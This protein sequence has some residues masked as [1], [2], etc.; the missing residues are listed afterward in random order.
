M[1]D[2]F[3]PSQ[4]SSEM[5]KKTISVVPTRVVDL[6]T[7]P[8]TTTIIMIPSVAAKKESSIKRRSLK[9][10]FCD[11]GSQT[12]VPPPH[13]KKLCELVNVFRSTL[14]DKTKWPENPLLLS[15]VDAEPSDFL[16]E[17][18]RRCDTPR[19]LDHLA[20]QGCGNLDH[21]Q[22]ARNNE[23]FIDTLELLDELDQKLD[24]LDQTLEQLDDKM[25]LTTQLEQQ[26]DEL[27]DKMDQQIDQLDDKIDQQFDQLEEKMDQQLDELED[28]MDLSTGSTPYLDLPVHPKMP[29]IVE[30]YNTIPVDPRLIRHSKLCADIMA[31]IRDDPNW[32]GMVDTAL[33]FRRTPAT[34]IDFDKNLFLKL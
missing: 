24:H 28:K 3:T 21:M 7:D 25:D 23:K 17:G 1:S 26:L 18:V 2:Y 14:P 11:V 8:P 16:H 19:P 13:K 29:T 10:K 32:T 12:M 15:M 30:P 6:T 27:E 4:T 31:D 22:D 5:D 20:P 33:T 34:D 9:R